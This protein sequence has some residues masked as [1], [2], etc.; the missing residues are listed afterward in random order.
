W[1]AVELIA[2]RNGEAALRRFVVAASSTGSD[3]EVRAATD[4]ALRDVLGTTREN[5]TGEWREHLR[6]LAS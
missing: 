4:R 2:A 6:S 5:L 1:Q 3:A